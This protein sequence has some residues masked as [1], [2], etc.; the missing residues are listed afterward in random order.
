MMLI[1]QYKNDKWA[2][3]SARMLTTREYVFELQNVKN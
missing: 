1:A 3:D 2:S